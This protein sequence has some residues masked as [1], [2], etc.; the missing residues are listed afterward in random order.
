ME[1]KK[2]IA[3]IKNVFD[4]TINRSDQDEEC[5]DKCK[6]KSVQIAH[7]KSKTKKSMEENNHSRPV[8]Q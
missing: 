8:G 4:R 7:A 2:M 6:Q 1:M 3:E 5:I